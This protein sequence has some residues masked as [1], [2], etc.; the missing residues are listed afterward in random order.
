MHCS[1]ESKNIYSLQR[2]EDTV[3]F[4]LFKKKV[5]KDNTEKVDLR[6]DMMEQAR[7]ILQKCDGLPLAISTIGGFLATKPKTAVEWRRIHN[8]I[9]SELEINPEL[10]TI[11]TVLIRSYDGLPYH[12]KYCFLYLSIFPEDHKI[13]RTLVIRRRVTEGYAREMHGVT[14]EEAGDNYFEELL[15]RS[16]IL[17]GGEVNIYSGK[18]DSCQLHDLMRQICI[19]KARE[20]NLSFTLED[21]YSLSRTQGTI[22]HLAISSNWSVDRQTVFEKVM[23]L[24]HVRSMTVFGE[25]VSFFISEKMRFLRVLDLQGTYGLEDHHLDKIGE[26]MHLKFLSLRRCKRIRNLPNSLWSLQ[27]LQ[28]LDIRCTRVRKLAPNITNLRELQFLRADG[29]TVPRKIG[30]L[31]SL[32]TLAHVRIY[33]EVKRSIQGFTQLYQLR[34]LGAGEITETNSKEFWSAI[35]GL[36]HLRSLS[37]NWLTSPS[38]KLDYSLGGSLLPPRSIENL[39]LFS[40]VVQLTEWIH[41]LQNLS[42]LKLWCTELQQDAVLALG[43][44]P[45]LT[46][47]VMRQES[48]NGKELAFKN[49]SFPSLVLL[50]LDHIAYIPCVKFDD[51]TMPKLELLRIVGWWDL[52]E[53]SGL[54]WLAKLK[55]IRLINLRGCREFKDNIQKQLT[56]HQNKPNLLRM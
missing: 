31:N 25:W 14:A 16:M 32:C 30:K 10:R 37:I 26:L 3:A 12:L 22:R 51:G 24:S 34:K 46:I 54:K 50:E 53:L 27:N 15:D 7:L 21:G 49:G 2:L 4:D 5:F 9:S 48:C 20:E 41:Q 33:E 36:N 6:P 56:E 45:N 40:R 35:D 38:Y 39:K 44:L 43:K 55:E 42:R 19:L 23:D 17:T 11:K 1:R 29:V 47:L 28:T 52:Q 8:H 13:R 18:I